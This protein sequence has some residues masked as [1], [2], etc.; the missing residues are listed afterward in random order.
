M[1]MDVLSVSQVTQRVKAL[2]DDDEQLADL[3]VEGEVSSFSRASSGHCYFT[4]K[5]VESE[6]RCVMWRHQAG[7]L[8]RLPTQG[9][10]VEAHG[11]VSVYERG[12]TYQ[13]YADL[14]EFGGIGARWR[15]FQQLKERLQAEGLFD[16]ARKRPL[17]KWPHRVGVVTSPTGAAFQDILNVLR[18]RYP[19]VEVVL[20]P[21]LVQGEEA[22]EA[23][24][25]AIERLNKMEAIDV[26]IVARG[27]G[28]LEAL[29][30]FNDERVARAVAACR[31]PVVSG[32]GHE[33][34]FTITDFVA[35][36]RA[37]TPSA[38]AAVVVPDARDLRDQVR[39]ATRNLISFIRNR[40]G[41]LQETLERETRLLR[42]HD[43][44]RALAE[45]RQRADD[46][47][48]RAASAVEHRLKL[49]QLSLASAEAKLQALSPR[50]VLERGYA[51]VQE[52][53]SGLRI[54]SA[55]QAAL[56]SDVTIHLH[57]GRLGANVTEVLETGG[58]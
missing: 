21:S 1:R 27:G 55:K 28:S 20:S 7:R 52:R 10:W 16:E 15:E 56:G 22:P 45:Q 54:T 25:G 46:L 33:T 13:L 18:A 29:W 14:I 36:L 12:G 24:V 11:Y 57:E 8:L 5:D 40:L 32:V 38:A 19:L 43:P 42:L 58:L 9:D 48:R 4:L 26:V 51:L 6:L 37:P 47:L 53:V 31:V 17:P 49:R 34:D 44:Q 23:L 50:S 30:A 3:W 41:R 2:L 39:A 35:D